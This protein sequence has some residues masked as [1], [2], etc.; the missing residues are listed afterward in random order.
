MKKLYH[1]LTRMIEKINHVRTLRATPLLI[2]S[3]FLF[4]FSTA[5]AQNVTILPQ[6]NPNPIRLQPTYFY[7]DVRNNDITNP[8]T[9]LT[10][11]ATGS[12]GYT[13]FPASRTVNIDPG[14]TERYQFSITAS[15]DVEQMGGIISYSLKDGDDVV[16]ETT[17]TPIAITESDFKIIAPG[18][19]QAD[20]ISTTET[21]TRIWAITGSAPAA[22]VSNVRV[23]FNCDKTSVNIVGIALVE[24]MLG[25][26]PLDIS[27]PPGTFFDDSQPNKYIYNLFGGVFDYYGF[28]DHLFHTDETVYI[29][30]TLKVLKCPEVAGT[31]NIEYGNGGVWCEDPNYAIATTSVVPLN[32]TY[33]IT[34]LNEVYP[35]TQTS[36]G[37][38]MLRLQNNSVDPRAVLRNLRLTVNFAGCKISVKKAYFVDAAGNDLGLPLLIGSTMSAN[39]TLNFSSYDDASLATLGFIEN[40]DDGRFDD[41]PT[42]I[43]F[44]LKFEY[45]FNVSCTTGCPSVLFTDRLGINFNFFNNCDLST[46]TGTVYPASAYILG[47]NAPLSSVVEPPNLSSSGT[48]FNLSFSEASATAPSGFVINRANYD[49]YIRIT[50]PQ[51]FDY[52]PLVPGITINGLSVPVGDITK[53]TIPP[54]PSS[55][56]PTSPDVVVLVIHNTIINPTSPMSYSINLFTNDAHDCMDKYFSIVHEWAFKDDTEHFQYACSSTLLNYQVMEGG[57]C[58]QI[59]NFNIERM[60]FGWTDQ[61][62]TERI[63]LSNI[64]DYPGVNRNVAGPYDDVDCSV[65]VALGCDMTWD[66]TFRWMV[67]LRYNDESSAYFFFPDPLKAV[68]ISIEGRAHVYIP[69]SDLIF[70]FDGA[71]R[72]IKADLTPFTLYPG[73]EVDPA[74]VINIVYKLQPTENIPN[75][76][77]LIYNVSMSSYIQTSL[78]DETVVGGWAPY[79]L[80]NYWLVDYAVKSFNGPPTTQYYVEN[81]NF[82]PVVNNTLCGRTMS[83][84]LIWTDEYRPDQFAYYYKIDFNSA[85]FISNVYAR[86]YQQTP[87]PPLGVSNTSFTLDPS[88]YEITNTD[89]K[90]SIEITKVLSSNIINNVSLFYWYLDGAPYCPIPNTASATV[91]YQYYPSSAN[92]TV[93]GQFTQSDFVAFNN[94]RRYRTALSTLE[95]SSYMVAHE[96]EWDF[97]LTNMSYWA[98]TDRILPNSWLSITL[99]ATVVTSSIILDDG[100][101]NTFTF[102][103]FTSY[104]PGKYWI[105]LGN[106]DFLNTTDFHLWCQY[107][108]CDPFEVNIMFGQCRFGYPV[109]PDYG[110]LGENPPCPLYS[111]L[112]L[113]AVP[114]LSSVRGMVDSPPYDGLDGYTFCEQQTYTATFYNTQSSHLTDL[115]LQMVLCTGLELDHSSVVANHNGIPVN[116]IDID[117]S[118]PGSERIVT[119][120]LEPTA[121]LLSNDEAPGGDDELSVTFDLNPICNFSNGYV[122]YLTFN[123]TSPCGEVVEETKHT[124]P[125]LIDGLSVESDYLIN[126]F[127]VESLAGTDIDLSSATA[128]AAAAVSIDANVVNNSYAQTPNDYLAI[129]IPPNMVINYSNF[130]F[131]FWKIESGNHIYKA[132]LTS[133][134]QGTSIPVEVILKPVDPELWD[135]ND[136][137]I[138]MFTGI[139]VDL[140]CKGIPCG[141]DVKHDNLKN[142]TFHVIKSSVEFL[143]GSVSATGVYYSTTS[144]KVTFSGTLTV[145][146]ETSIEDLVIEV[147]SNKTATLL[148]V[149]GA[150]FIIDYVTTDDVTTEVPF[151]SPALEIPAEDMCDL[152]LVIRKTAAYNLYIC[153]NASIPVPTPAYTLAKTEYEVCSGTNSVVGTA[154]AITGYTYTWT[155]TTYIVGSNTGAQITVNYPSSV[156][157]I[158]QALTLVINRGGCNVSANVTVDVNNCYT[159]TYDGNGNDDGTAPSD[160]NSPYIEDDDVTVLGPGTLSK[161]CHTFIGWASTATATTPNFAYDGADFTPTLF[162]ITQDTVLYAVWRP[163]SITPTFT[164][165]PVTYC[166]GDIPF[167]LS[168]ALTSDNGVTGTW[169]PAAIQTAIPTA[170]GVPDEYTFTPNAG[171]C[172]RTAKIEITIEVCNLLR[173]IDTKG[174]P[175]KADIPYEE[176]GYIHLGAAWD[177]LLIPA[178]TADSVR[179]IVNGEIVSSGISAT[180]NG[181]EFPI[182][183]SEV[184]VVAYYYALTD[185][186]EFSVTIARTCPPVAVDIEGNIYKVTSLAGL[187]WTE[188]LK[189][190][191]CSSTGDSIPFA[192]SY[193]CSHCPAELDTIFGLLYTWDSAMCGESAGDLVQGICPEGW[194]IPTQAEWNRL[195]QYSA[196]SLM[197]ENYWLNSKGTNDYGFDARP[198]GWYNGATQRFEDLYAFTG[199]WASD[200]VVSHNSLA[201][202]FYLTY[203]CDIILK[204]VQSKENG[205]SVR[206]VI[207]LEE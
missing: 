151:I 123:A 1:L 68:E 87:G 101:G 129:S 205:L 201:N 120:T 4:L 203:Y 170:A 27:T 122:V 150:A 65:S 102:V 100:F 110:F 157:G 54:D 138:S 133:F 69:E 36:G 183:V 178:P 14:E 8:V 61:T 173:C 24:D 6:P 59:A 168:S 105:Q 163:D 99:P 106:L 33:P 197:S 121:T 94:D 22:A 149:A 31:Y 187:C 192:E 141:I 148:P 20:Y 97:T 15:C 116:V 158:T 195:T 98:T 147:F 75:V 62:M 49:H 84:A 53:E 23:T 108:A 189:S 81:L 104:A 164:I 135:C 109:N 156:A 13:V 198:A 167:D 177:A 11:Y 139:Y 176:T 103:D 179:Y 196:S 155:P 171:Q 166:I 127:L 67:D 46:N 140:A 16:R 90:T 119:I 60:T 199:W 80:K 7:V 89:G 113:Y 30:E 64:G 134:P 96:A 95:A 18:D 126:S 2:L 204:E 66:G 35:T 186:C 52:N 142:E 10:L 92:D 181:V 132:P 153:D 56:Y 74:D 77:T 146:I 78:A 180:L 72:S 21:Y 188:N 124:I 58:I 193:T 41:L 42:G 115:V 70:S 39:T 162:V 17:T 128:A 12:A 28:A 88:E 174:V 57:G 206:C 144:E 202:Y 165:A 63:T 154:N 130:T 86:Q 93:F 107:I 169:S 175:R 79:L 73:K 47:Y 43:D 145:P 160:P 37:T 159:V 40:D 136:V 190:T 26:N 5:F 44:Y 71:A 38:F 137:S 194:R 29:Q 112:K 131:T 83:A 19:I 9:G 50:L 114:A 143:A 91:K 172:A 117:D 111:T 51:G 34:L 200:E 185:T 76:L 152:Y 48:P 184:T 161:T 191:I 25:T 45:D 207:D 32:Y 118:G 3:F 85:W 82:T 55:C 125:L 182:G